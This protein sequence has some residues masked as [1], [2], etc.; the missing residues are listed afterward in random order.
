MADPYFQYEVSRVRDYNPDTGA[1]LVITFAGTEAQMNTVAAY[2][3][4]AGAGAPIGYGYKTNFYKT[5]A[6]VILTVRIPDSI[7]YTERWN[8]NTEIGSL[9]IWY[10]QEIKSY[11]GCIAVPP[12]NT[13][14]VLLDEQ[15]LFLRGLLLA[16]KSKVIQ[17]LDPSSSVFAASNY[18]LIL[19]DGSED[20]NVI[21]YS[22]EYKIVVGALI[23]FGENFE[24]K[25][26]VLR[27][28]RYMPIAS[29]SRTN[30]AGLQIIYTTAQLISVWSIPADI[31]LQI[32]TV[33]TGLPAAATGTMWAWKER[34]NESDVVIGSGRFQECR[35]WVYGRW[36]TLTHTLYTP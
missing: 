5:A 2:Y 8:L 33:D 22:T 36:S 31:V 20:G 23:E 34:Q 11:L 27:R 12:S 21:T 3:E 16:A 13:V 6:G 17:G 1:S 15:Y 29:T 35:D 18:H 10:S 26:P 4:E 32:S 30:L 28:V 9:P 19:P 7:L 14:Q 24:V 25:R